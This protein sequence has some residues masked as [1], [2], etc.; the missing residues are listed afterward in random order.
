MLTSSFACISDPASNSS[1][2]TALSPHIAATCKAV[3]PGL[4]VYNNEMMMAIILQ[5][6]SQYHLLVLYY[7]RLSS[8]LLYIILYCYLQIIYITTKIDTN[9]FKLCSNFVQNFFKNSTSYYSNIIH[10][11]LLYYA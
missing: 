10:S 3:Q 8:F 2:T 6:Y 11:R 5:S 7:Y 9:F 1:P 4:Y